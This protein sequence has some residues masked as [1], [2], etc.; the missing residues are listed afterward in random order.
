MN[1]HL[2]FIGFII[3]FLFPDKK[4]VSQVNT[5]FLNN[6]K[7]KITSSCA[8]PYPC[9]QNETYN[10]YTSGDTVFNSLVY[11]KVFQ[12]GFGTYSWMSTL[13]PSSC[14]GGYSYN[15]PLPNY[16][17]R[18]SGKQIY[19]R[20][21]SDTNEYLLYDFDLSIGD[22][23]PITY[24]NYATDV[25]VIA[26]DSIYTPYGYYKR[27]EL[28]GSTLSPY[29][30]EGIGSTKGLFEAMGSI[31]ECGYNLVCF[32]LNDSAYYP[33]IGG[34]CALTSGIETFENEDTYSIFPN[35]VTNSFTVETRLT[36]NFTLTVIDN[37]GQK[38]L[39]ESC[40]T[41]RTTVN[42]SHL[43]HGMYFVQLKSKEGLVTKKLMVK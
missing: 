37:L 19:M 11:K 23:L 39:V 40:S 9:I 17:L 35:P 24:N 20:Q 26:I 2:S 16:F 8:I 32:A 12:K 13:P 4:S 5:Y 38:V 43:K 25:K 36:D 31:L 18:S 15:Y 33:S 28:T 6:P 34:G 14:S 27:F 29:L 10:Y 3:L 21:L 41:Q 7:W 30:I 1:K 22:T 42:V